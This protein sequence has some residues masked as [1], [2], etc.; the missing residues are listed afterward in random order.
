LFLFL[1]LVFVGVSFV[2]LL[3]WLIHKNRFFL[4]FCL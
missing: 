2:N 1:I 4:Y 3:C